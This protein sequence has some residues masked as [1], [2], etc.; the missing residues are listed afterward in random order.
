MRFQKQVGFS[1]V[2][3]EQS[4]SS[5]ATQSPLVHRFATGSF[6]WS[7]DFSLFS[8]GTKSGSRR[9]VVRSRLSERWPVAPALMHRMKTLATTC[10]VIS[11][12]VQCSTEEKAIK[13]EPKYLTNGTKAPKERRRCSHC[14]QMSE[15]HGAKMR[16]GKPEFLVV[17]AEA[18]FMEES[19]T[20]KIHVVT[21][22]LFGRWLD[23][24]RGGE[25]N[26]KQ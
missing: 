10:V 2:T 24:V 8:V 25:E 23:I 18:S 7:S 3:N 16:P 20:P 14:V 21:R 22:W 26:T 6:H 9:R 13:Q 1:R 5:L 12:S 17:K 15:M 11:K 19:P 4:S